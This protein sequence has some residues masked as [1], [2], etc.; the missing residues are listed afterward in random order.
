MLPNKTLITA[1][2]ALLTAGA[3]LDAAQAQGVSPPTANLVIKD[4]EYGGVNRV[5]GV[6]GA[7]NVTIANIGTADFSGSQGWAIFVG[8]NGGDHDSCIIPQP[9]F[10]PDHPTTRD[11][12]IRFPDVDQGN[13]VTEI[14]ADGRAYTFSLPVPWTADVDD[15]ELNNFIY[16]EI[17]P[18]GFPPSNALEGGGCTGPEPGVG[19]GQAQPCTDNWFIER[20]VEVRRIGIRAEPLRDPPGAG[21]SRND[22]WRAADIRPSNVCDPAPANL[23]RGCYARPG[24]T[25]LALYR[26]FNVGNVTE[27]FT[28]TGQFSDDFLARKYDIVY[29]PRNITIEGGRDAIVE[30]RITIPE[31]DTALV[32]RTNVEL[33][34]ETIR[35]SSI[36]APQ[37][38]TNADELNPGCDD[39]AFEVYCVDPTLPSMI[40]GYRYA[41]NVSA[42]FTYD[43]LPQGG[44][45]EFLLN[46]T[47]NANTRDDYNITVNWERPRAEGL[48][49][50]GPGWDITLIEPGRPEG[51]AFDARLQA[52]GARDTYR[53]QVEAPG[54]IP[55]STYWFDVDVRSEGDENGTLDAPCKANE[56]RNTTMCTIRFAM[57][58]AQTFKLEGREPAAARVRSAQPHTYRV[59]FHNAGNGY[60]NLT[61]NVGQSVGG[62]TVVPS[63]RTLEFTPFNT[64]YVDLTVT[65]PPNTPPNTEASFYLNLTSSG[66][67]EASTEQRTVSVQSRMTI[68][69][70]PNLRLDAPV[71]STFVDA[72]TTVDYTITVT[73][74][75]N[76]V[77]SF[78]VPTPSRP[79]DWGV[80]VTPAAAFEL[81]PTQTQ[82]V[83][84]SLT[85]P[86][87]AEVGERATALVN[88]KSRVDQ[89]LSKEISLEGRVSGPDYFVDNVLVNSSSPY[90]GDQLEVTVALGNAGNR[91]ADTN[92]TLRVSFVQNGVERLIGE[93]VYP[94][95]S[96][97]G[98]RR[99]T[100]TFAWDT[101]GVEGGGVILARMDAG[102][103]VK[104]ID[105][106][107]A[108][109]ERTRAIT[110][111]TFEI[112]LTPAQGLTARPGERVSYDEAP[113]VV[114][115]EYKGN[116]ATEPVT[117]RF[118]SERGWLTSQSELTLALPRNT[119]LPVTATLEIPALPG[120]A[121][122][123]LTIEVIPALR[124]EEKLTATVTTTLLDEEKP[125]V[126]S[127]SAEPAVATLGT[128]VLIVANVEDATGVS[129]VTAYITSPTN[130]TSS[131]TLFK[132]NGERWAANKTFT[133][134]GRYRISVEAMDSATPANRNT[135]RETTGTFTLSPGSAPS[136]RLAQGQTSIIRTGSPIKLDIRDPLGIGKATY[137]IKGVSY[138]L[139]GP[140]YQIDT[141]TFQ[142]GSV[143]INVTAE[144]IYGVATSAKFTFNVDN[145]EPQIRE[146]TLTPERPRAN[147]DVRIAIQTDVEVESVDVLVKRGGQVVQ[148][149]NAT[150]TGA[151]RFTA[152]FNP[153]EGD[154][155]L[156]VT[157]RDGAG[158]TK[159]A[160]EAVVFSA[161]PA[162]FVPAAPLALL[163]LAMG[164][165]A[166][167]ARR[168]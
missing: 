140:A 103:T 65:S 37:I 78:E 35:W 154:Y 145:A 5:A 3:F 84:V 138:D 123:R 38:H 33:A 61:L 161:R 121:S 53:L 22:P 27:T 128:P 82:T 69:S 153:G 157:A 30:V 85:A 136:V 118:T 159:L 155:T 64:T 24:R 13:P 19:G 160:P 167:L 58:V 122:D 73:N 115:L 6:P 62:W 110:L 146:V 46:I 7:V 168:R 165:L 108:S 67:R 56:V 150:K 66:P 152:T 59:G 89:F 148:S 57:H 86:Q 87:G 92:A 164:A 120:V 34:T 93:K 95:F 28:P 20:N 166:L 77:D 158:N 163:V 117:V 11:C 137:A 132:V 14:P 10:E 63:N 126:K 1:L 71:N 16:A 134:A 102:D 81:H 90:S 141:S 54:Q 39:E 75:G 135:T 149:L 147:E 127:V 116:Q 41:F 8:L 49:T 47:N 15:A 111:R 83:T 131:L 113:H 109:N 43:E 98:Q 70:G 45:S 79:A 42:N 36:R 76:V 23:T 9:E 151:G 114:L 94:A 88:V 29:A 104:E 21:E 26:L 125:I 51:L 112:K 124:P 119:P 12:Y 32:N 97:A 17:L 4:I 162:S 40:T 100:E 106:S 156:D 139:V 143:E 68:E 91:P 105:D 74:V 50:I 44:V 80:T 99:L 72:G 96:I 48:Q 129:A 31:N 25:Y 18:L 55:N 2:V 52:P 144:N 60:E 142:A 107:A 133:V 101:T 130:E